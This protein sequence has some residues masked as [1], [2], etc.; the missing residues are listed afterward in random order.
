MGT[1]IPP[2]PQKVQGLALKRAVPLPAHACGRAP[3]RPQEQLQQVWR[4]LASEDAMDRVSLASLL[5]CAFDDCMDGLSATEALSLVGAEGQALR[6]PQMTRLM[7]HP[8]YRQQDR[9]RYFVLVSLA[10]AETL[11][12]VLQC[13]S[14]RHAQVGLCMW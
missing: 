4:L 12:R 7:V 2:P 1:K 10:E 8:H 14:K 3:P 6:H 13:R 5:R 11:R 9:G